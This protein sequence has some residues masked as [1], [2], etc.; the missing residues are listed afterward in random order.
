MKKLFFILCCILQLT[1]TVEAAPTRANL[2]LELGEKSLAVLRSSIRPREIPRPTNTFQ[3]INRSPLVR[4]RI[5]DKPTVE[6]LEKGS[7][8]INSSVVSPR[9]TA[10]RVDLEPAQLPFPVIP[11]LVRP[12][13]RQHAPNE[14]V[15]TYL[16][17]SQKQERLH[18]TYSSSGASVWRPKFLNVAKVEARRFYSTAIG[19]SSLNEGFLTEQNNTNSLV[20]TQESALL[21]SVS[22][23]AGQESE[24][25]IK[26]AL[27]IHYGIEVSKIA[28]L[29]LGADMNAS[30]Y[31]AQAHNQSPYLVKIK[32]GYPHDIS[33]IITELLRNAG[34]QQI[35]PIVKTTN[36]QA[37]QLVGDFTMMVSPFV[38]GQDGFSRALTADQWYGLGKVMRQ[39]HE[40]NVPPS[41]QPKI[42]REFYSSK[43]RQAVRAL[44]PLIES[45]STGDISAVNFLTFIKKHKA[46][47]NRLVDRAEQLAQKVQDESSPFVLCHSDIHGGNVLLGEKDTLYILDWDDPIMA[48]KERDLMFIGG[49]IGN[50]WNKPYEEKLFYKGYGRTE[51][52]MTLL[53][54][55]RHERIV[56]DIADYGQKLLLTTEGGQDRFKW[57]KE[58]I[59]QFEPQGVVDIA[60]KTNENLTL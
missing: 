15:L 28:L 13:L 46:T 30:V 33:A 56:E 7:S 40:I 37:T 53:S 34:I 10:T 55:Y 5:L 47:I 29:P 45:E 41:I 9:I 6:L 14:G 2:L 27:K 48:P 4:A 43:W 11:D 25:I 19:E 50:I 54:Y 60:F 12:S 38:D 44:Y 18:N 59:D 42:R 35:K 49:G 17:K 3:K 20:R 57:Y 24:N 31:K 23:Q 51:V 32:R 52:N 21:P 58:F 16:L 39:I 1:S 36:G 8:I 22:I 26:Q